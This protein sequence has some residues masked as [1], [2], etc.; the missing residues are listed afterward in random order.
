MMN[1]IQPIWEKGYRVVEPQINAEGTHLYPFDPAFP[2]DVRFFSFSGRNRIRMNRHHYCEIYY[3]A[4]GKT[5][6]QV[7]DRCFDVTEK[8]AVVIGGDLYHRTI[9]PPNCKLRLV[10]L[11]FE[12]ELIRTS[13]GTSEETEYLMPFFTQ[14][15]DFPHVV[16][17][18]G[19]LPREILD[20]MLRIH[21]ELPATTAHARL[22]VKTYLKMILLLLVKHYAAYLGGRKDID[23]QQAS[24]ERLRPLFAHL[25]RNVDSPI[26]I[27]EAARLC[28]MSK[29]HFMYFF[30]RT[31]GQSFTSYV[32]H[33]RIAKAQD[34]LATTNEPIS[35][36]SE[37]L[38]FC[39]QS[40]FGMVFRKLV[41]VTPLAY[42]RQFANG[43]KSDCRTSTAVAARGLQTPRD[44]RRDV[45]VPL[46]AINYSASTAATEVR[47][48]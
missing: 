46:S 42:R 40:Y 39:N 30:K 45:R 36:I 27:S 20:F 22:A 1:S 11:F 7:Q 4:S 3:V 16:R 23:R 32:N 8:D 26:L 35:S 14:G 44:G 5:T 43:R 10:V 37:G 12:P 21:A 15:A 18:N 19:R 34:L 33:F 17:G 48:Q 13:C 38:A 24:I 29:S 47:S 25:E 41:G 28:A 31:T 9:D 6:V 2:I